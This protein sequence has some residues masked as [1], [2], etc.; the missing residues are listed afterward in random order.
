MS[1]FCGLMSRCKTRHRA[2]GARL[3]LRDVPIR[4]RR[5]G[6]GYV[7]AVEV[8]EHQEHL[9]RGD[10]HVEDS[11]NVRVAEL[12]EQLELVLRDVQHLRVVRSHRLD[13][14]LLTVGDTD[15]TLNAARRSLAQLLEQC[16]LAV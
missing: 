16:V 15:S 10:E 5:N 3:Q 4:R 1:T 9:L 11:N 14:N 2:Q 6:L 12:P 7:Q 8:L 13:G